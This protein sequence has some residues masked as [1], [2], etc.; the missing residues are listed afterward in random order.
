M[1]TEKGK[2]K[3]KVG[4]SRIELRLINVS[5]IITIRPKSAVV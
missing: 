2:V 1:G 4:V 5:L 3:E